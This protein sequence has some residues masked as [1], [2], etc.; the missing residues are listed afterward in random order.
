MRFLNSLR[1]WLCLWRGTVS[2]GALLAGLALVTAGCGGGN[3]TGGTASI[4][5]CTSASCG[6][7]QVALTDADGDFLR[8]SVG[9]VSIDL[10]KADGTPVHLLPAS[11]TQ[12]DFAQL[13]N[14]SEILTAANLPQ[15]AYNKGSITLDYTNADIEVEVAGQAVKATVAD[16]QGNP[17]AQY[18]LQ[19][20]LDDHEPLVVQADHLKLLTLDFNLAASNQVDTTRT[21]P[22]VTV[23]PF[24]AADIDQAKQKQTRVRGP[25][26][27]VDVPGMS[28]TVDVRPF[29][30]D[31]TGHDGDFGQV[32]VHVDANTA[33]EV[34]GAAS[35]GSAGLDALKALPA[36]SPTSARG[37]INIDPVTQ[38]HTFLASSVKAGDSVPGHGRDA[39]IGNV[40][41]R[42]GNTLMVKGAT[43]MHDD[44]RV[45]FNDNVT[46]TIGPNTDVR[47][48]DDEQEN[49][50]HEQ[51]QGGGDSGSHGGNTPLDIGAI[52]VGQRV[53]VHGVVS[54]TQ[55]VT[56]DAM[57]GRVRL[58][59]THI[60]GTIGSIVPGQLTMALKS[61]DH[62]DVGIFDFA[63]TGASP[64]ED[65]NP[66]SYQVNTSLLT[67][68]EAP[69][70]PV[71]ISGFV[72]PFGQA[73]ATAD[74]D[75]VQVEDLG[76][77]DHARLVAGW[78]DMG[79]TAPFASLT[80]AGL[81]L[82]LANASLGT[83]DSGHFL[84][85]DG[86]VLDLKTLTPPLTI[87]P[88]TGGE[89]HF[90]IKQGHS[91]QAFAAFAD[92]VTALNG[93]VD[94]TN[95]VSGLYSEGT[96]DSATG[97]FAARLVLVRVGLDDM[98]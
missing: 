45:D 38:A 46:V 96:Y 9:V 13:V 56:I 5:G 29:D 3:S 43:I 34:N 83:G 39:I 62:R 97:N 40:V 54:G 6:T 7:V 21:P 72:V 58:L 24:L 36:G 51:S 88:A 89:L 60:T 41:S 95:V 16:P 85:N 87:L 31:D 17:L 8:Y 90:A 55:S 61:I 19:I 86:G 27:S 1:S 2:R 12:V 50:L 69:G 26:V 11:P 49:A 48:D 20:T 33:F 94:G 42:S 15:G 52:S 84:L 74:F 79:T 63:G 68:S 23:S 66:A 57:N 98:H 93:L 71:G 18:T 67:L 76:S 82:D 4:N 73:T 10:V 77:E 47:R 81:V 14:L 53:E 75:A 80:N 44:G 92:F 35:T 32:V 59:P 28:Y 22:V 64:L 30:R 78:G 37:M 25:L 65:A 91:V 70:A